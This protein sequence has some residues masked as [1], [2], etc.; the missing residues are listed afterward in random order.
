V[1]KRSLDGKLV[2]ITGAARGIGRATA[3]ALVAEGARVVLSDLDGDLAEQTAAELGNGTVGIQLDVTDHGAFSAALDRVEADHGPLDI[4]INNAGIMAAVPFV[5]E[6]PESRNR[7]IAVNFLAPWHATQDGIRRMRPRGRGHILNVASLG[8][9]VA[10]PGAATYSAT[11]HAVVGL[12]E[13]VSWEIRG[14]GI[15]LG[16]VLPAMVNTELADG[17]KRTRAAAAI[18]PEEVAQL[19]VK[20]LQKPKRTIYAPSR[21]SAVMRWSNLIPGWLGDKLMLASGSDHLISDALASGKRAEYEQR[22][23]RS[24]PGADH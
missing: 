9:V 14:S 24:A 16:C 18:E 12:T 3:K 22:V 10:M 6:T 5:D 23:A 19:I 1:A 4:L 13:T 2:F 20:A 17:M 7:Q 15:D 11:K 21:M 8:G